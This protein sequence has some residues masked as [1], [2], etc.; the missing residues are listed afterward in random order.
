MLSA[1]P[2]IF[3]VVLVVQIIGKSGCQVDTGDLVSKFIFRIVT[4]AGALLAVACDTVADDLMGH[5]AVARYFY[6]DG[7]V[8]ND[9]FMAA[10]DDACDEFLCS[11]FS[12]ALLALVADSSDFPRSGA[13]YPRRIRCS[14]FQ[15][16]AVL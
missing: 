10:F 4:V 9:G 13:A 14:G 6:S 2:R 3:T 1:I 5:A 12:N 15:F 8:L 7:A 16:P 11:A